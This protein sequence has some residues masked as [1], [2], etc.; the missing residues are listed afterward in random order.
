MQSEENQI[1]CGKGENTNYGLR[2]ERKI[3]N[4]NGGRRAEK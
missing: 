4:A 2:G 3:K 1:C